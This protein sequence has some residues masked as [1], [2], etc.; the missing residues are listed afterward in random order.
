MSIQV[1]AAGI[2]GILWIIGSIYIGYLAAKINRKQETEP[3]WPF[4][5]LMVFAWP[6]IA[7]VTFF[8]LLQVVALP[9]VQAKRRL[10]DQDIDT[11]CQEIY[12]HLSTK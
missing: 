6:G 12:K 1:I 3:Y 2:L 4:V 7:V 8:R 5:L 11:L 9:E 10:T